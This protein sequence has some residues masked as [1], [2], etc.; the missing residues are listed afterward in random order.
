MHMRGLPYYGWRVVAALFVV[1]MMV[2]GGGLYAFTLFIPPLTTEFGWSRA[3]TGGL[4]S[5]FWLAAPLTLAGS[6]FNQRFGAFRLVSAGVILEGLCMVGVG[7]THSLT[8]MFVIRALMGLGK[9]MMAAGVNLQASVWF[10]R[11]FGMAIAVCYAGWHFGGLVLAPVSQFC[12]DRFGWRTTSFLLGALIMIVSLPLLIVWGRVRAPADLG[13]EVD[14]GASAGSTAAAQTHESAGSHEAGQTHEGSV[15]VGP[16]LLRTRVF[17]SAVAVT[18]LGGVAY[19]GLLT[20][21]VALINEQH[22]AHSVAALALSLTAGAALI[23][24]LLFGYLSDRL[25]FRLTMSCELGLMVASVLGFLMFDET[26][27]TALL[28]MSATAFGVSVGGFDACIVAHIRKQGTAKS[29]ADAFGVW[30]FTFLATLFIAPIAIGG[31]FD[32]FGN[33]RT[34]L[35]VMAACVAASLLLVLVSGAGTRRT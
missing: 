22:V 4:V 26:P 21:E 5:I 29:F 1:G 2:Y 14:G 13:L 34:S 15:L 25:P 20:H 17:W 30:Y 35:Q 27:G 11:R 9:I 24:A 12:I 18:V 19:G 7:L 23:G 28:L 6:Y 31:L 33:Y 8:A 10:R 32:R 3:A 16:S